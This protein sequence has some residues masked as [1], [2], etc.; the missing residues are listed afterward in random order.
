MTVLEIIET[1]LITAASI[2]AACLG[3][4]EAIK[5]KWIN[6]IYPSIKT[7]VI[8]AQN[9]AIKVEEKLNYALKYV[10]LICAE[11]HIPY[12]LIKRKVIKLYEQLAEGYNL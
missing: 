6:D 2:I 5:N 3:T 4:L 12:W 9:E 11:E 7:A 10:Q 1:V 8:D